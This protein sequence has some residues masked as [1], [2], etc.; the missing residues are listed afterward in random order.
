MNFDAPG[1]NKFELNPD[2]I[3]AVEK[4]KIDACDKADLLLTKAGLKPAT[5]IELRIS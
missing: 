5:E 4:L 1:K 3:S 2:F